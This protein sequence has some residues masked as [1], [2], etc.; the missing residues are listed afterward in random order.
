[1]ACDTQPV[2][3]NQSLSQRKQEVRDVI[4][5]I[6]RGLQSGRIKAVVDAKTRAVA[7]VGDI[8]DRKKVSDACVFKTMSAAERIAIEKAAGRPI[9]MQAMQQGFHSHDGVTFATHKH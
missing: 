1:M 3:A 7:F 5:A 8:G 2:R 6:K 9:S 4:A